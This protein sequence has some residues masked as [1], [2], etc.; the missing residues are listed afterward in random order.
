ML[1]RSGVRLHRRTERIRRIGQ[2]GSACQSTPADQ[3]VHPEVT[4][5]QLADSLGREMG[6]QSPFQGGATDR[7][8]MGS[9]IG[10]DLAQIAGDRTG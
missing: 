3:A 6:H 8:D 2:P 10:T 7:T 5:I 4:V 9:C 1:P